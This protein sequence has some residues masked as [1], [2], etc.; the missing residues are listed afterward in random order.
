M[1]PEAAEQIQDSPMSVK[2]ALAESLPQRVVL[3]QVVLR[4]K[5]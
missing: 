5:G 2:F 3:D 4:K 1:G